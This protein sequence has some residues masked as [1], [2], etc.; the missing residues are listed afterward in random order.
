MISIM[1]TIVN[2]RT[3]D[4]QFILFVGRVRYY[5]S[6]VNELRSKLVKLYFWFMLGIA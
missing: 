5:T 2:N 1:I 3:S 6:L 4:D